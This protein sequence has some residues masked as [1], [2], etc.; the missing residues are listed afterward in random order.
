MKKEFFKNTV[1][2]CCGAPVYEGGAPGWEGSEV[3]THCAVC[4]KCGDACDQIPVNKLAKARFLLINYDDYMEL[5]T[6]DT[7]EVRLKALSLELPDIKHKLDLPDDVPY[8]LV[9]TGAK[10]SGYVILPMIM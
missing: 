10:S 2:A 4:N 5:L 8:D 3:F 7:S 9:V 1:S 6:S